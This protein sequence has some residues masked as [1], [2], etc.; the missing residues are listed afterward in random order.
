[1][2]VVPLSLV[3][4][5]S[6][7][8]GNAFR[9]CWGL[10][11]RLTAAPPYSQLAAH[12]DR[13]VGRRAVPSRAA[14]LRIQVCAS[15]GFDFPASRILVVGSGLLARNV[16]VALAWC[17]SMPS[18]ARHKCWGSPSAVAA[19]S[20]VRSC[21]GITERSFLPQPVDLITMFSFTLN[22]EVSVAA[23]SEVL[24]SVWA[25]P[26]AW[27][28]L[29]RR[30]PDTAPERDSPARIAVAHR[31]EFSSVDRVVSAWNRYSLST[32]RPPIRRTSLR[33]AACSG[34]APR[35]TRPLR[36][37]FSRRARSR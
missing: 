16:G 11:M 23:L 32:P 25:Q 24:E 4:S 12:Y 2:L 13:F 9:W 28:F 22:L 8:R 26:A 34:G 29:D 14:R 7:S 21:C 31:R 1:M 5:T 35:P 18:I 20:L 6:S 30:F 15:R 27:R 36:I 33:P 37:C 10:I 3:L 19:G 17:R